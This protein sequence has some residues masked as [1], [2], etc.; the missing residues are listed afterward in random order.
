MMSPSP[1]LVMPGPV[2]GIHVLSAGPKV[3]DGRDIFAKT[4][5]ALLP[6]HD[7]ISR[8]RVSHLWISVPVPW[9]V[10]S[11]SSTACCILPSM[12]T[13]PSTPCSSA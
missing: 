5:F 6:G 2:P 3:V 11:S 9:L 7:E 1:Q 13:T 10:K 12:M 4:R 8:L